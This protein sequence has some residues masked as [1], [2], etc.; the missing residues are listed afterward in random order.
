MRAPGTRR[1]ARWVATPWEGEVIGDLA[2]AAVRGDERDHARREL[3]A[4]EVEPDAV[5]VRFG[6]MVSAELGTGR[7]AQVRFG[8]RSEAALRGWRR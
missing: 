3:A 6:N 4:G 8:I 2:G 1:A 5:G 7:C